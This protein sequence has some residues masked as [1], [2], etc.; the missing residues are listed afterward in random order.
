MFRKNPRRRSLYPHEP[1]A[2]TSTP[3]PTPTPSLSLTLSPLTSPPLTSP[4]SPPTR[5]SSGDKHNEE[6]L[7]EEVLKHFFP[8]RKDEIIDLF[9]K[10][11]K[12]EKSEKGEKKSE[13][14]DVDDE[15]P[16]YLA[17]QIEKNDKSKNKVLK[18][19]PPTIKIKV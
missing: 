9:K 14:V 16:N 4:P 12:S 10:D 2:P 7:A 13:K 6:V 5:K 3:T 18:R 19:I 11:E 17:D 15:I 8:N 1:L